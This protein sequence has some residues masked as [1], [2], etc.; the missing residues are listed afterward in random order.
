[1]RHYLD[2]TQLSAQS[3]TNKKNMP[4]MLAICCGGCKKN[5]SDFMTVNPT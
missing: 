3:P 5:S 1:M 4:Q 2:N